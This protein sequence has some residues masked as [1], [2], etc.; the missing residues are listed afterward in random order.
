LSIPYPHAPSTETPHNL[1]ETRLRAF[2]RTEVRDCTD[3]PRMRRMDTVDI[4]TVEQELLHRYAAY[5]RHGEDEPPWRASDDVHITA[6]GLY[7]LYEQ[8][9]QPGDVIAVIDGGKVPVV[10][11]AAAESKDGDAEEAQYHL[12]C[13]A[14]L[15][16]YMDGE[17]M[18]EMEAGRLRKERV[19]LV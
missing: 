8:G 11:R 14:Y 3:P 10:L 5:S 9:P 12:V 18:G 2:A 16:G 7:A 1:N 6:S 13:V 19:W 15:H 4:D 17:A